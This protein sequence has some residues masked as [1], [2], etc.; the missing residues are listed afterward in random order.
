MFRLNSLLSQF[1][2]VTISWLI[3]NFAIFCKCPPKNEYFL[4]SRYNCLEFV[5]LVHTRF[6][7]IASII[8]LSVSRP[9][10]GRLQTIQ[11][12]GRI[13]NTKWGKNRKPFLSETKIVTKNLQPKVEMLTIGQRKDYFLP[14][15]VGKFLVVRLQA[16][17]L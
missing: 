5:N 1:V 17:N 6:P 11:A 16:Q 13:L 8:L 15:K 2:I 3:F 10:G 7:V 4:Y 14:I 12:C 9:S